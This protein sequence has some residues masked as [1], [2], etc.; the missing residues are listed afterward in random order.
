MLAGA[1][2]WRSQTTLVFLFGMPS[3]RSAVAASSGLGAGQNRAAVLIGWSKD[4]NR[5]GV[6]TLAGIRVVG[7][8]TAG[9]LL[10]EY[11]RGHS[12]EAGPKELQS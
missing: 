6:I 5:L 2:P 3:D 4:G 7:N 1:V 11:G 9:Q 10:S 12:H 8:C